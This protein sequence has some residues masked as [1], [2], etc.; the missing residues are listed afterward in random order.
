MKCVSHRFF[1]LLLCSSISAWL[2]IPIPTLRADSFDWRNVNGANWNT[3]VQNQNGGT[4]WVFSGV[5]SFEARYKLTRNDPT[6]DFECSEQQVEW[7]C[8]PTQWGGWGDGS[9]F[10]SVT[11]GLV[12]A[13]ECPIDPNPDY[14]LSPGPTSLW[15]LAAGWQNRMLIG[16]N[17]TV[18]TTTTPNTIQGASQIVCTTQNIKNMLKMYG[19]MMTAVLSTNDLYNSPA[20]I[21][22]NYRPPLAGVDHAV[23]VEG[24]QDDASLPSGGYWIIKNSWGATAG[25]G[26]GYYDVPYGDLEIHGDIVAINTAV[27]YTGAMATVTWGGGTGT[28]SLGGGNWS[29]S[30]QYGNALPTYAWE[31]KETAATF[32]T[33]GGSMTINGTVIAH[34][35]TIASGATGYVF[36]GVN[37]GALTVTAGGITAHESVAFNVPVWIGAPQTWT[38]DSGKS[39]TIGDLHTIVSNLTINAAGNFYTSGAIDGGGVLNANGAAPGSVTFAGTGNFYAT[40]SSTVPVNLVCNS[41]GGVYLDTP[42]GQT[43]TWSGNISGTGSGTIHKTDQGMLIVSGSASYSGPTS[44]DGG[45]LQVSLPSGFLTLN[46]GVYQSNSSSAGTFTRGLATSGS[47]KFEWTAAGG[48]FAAGAG[49]LTVNVG[50]SSTAGT[51]TWG[52]TPGTNIIGTLMFGSST[53]LNATIFRNPVNLNGADRTI[54]VDDNPASAAD[55][56]AMQGAVFNNTGTAGL[57]KTGNGVLCLTSSG[58]NYNGNTTIS[59]GVLEENLPANSFLSLQ[60]G[61]YETVSGGTF[62]RSLGSSGGTFC[63]TGNGGGFSTYTSPLT[64]NVGGGSATLAW[65]TN[66]G[67]QIVGTLM[68]GST[69]WTSTVTFLNPIDL[70]GGARTISVADNPN[71]TADYAALPVAI[72]DSVGGGSLLKAGEGTL[73]LQGSASNTYSGSTTIQGTLVAA[74][75]GGA[76]ALPGNVTLL[77][78]GYGY[79]SVLQLNGNGELASSCF[80]TFNAPLGGSRLELNGHSQTLSGIS[81][82]A[83]AVIEGLLNN[84]GLN[85]DSLLTV[86]N[87]SD[88]T[89]LGVIRNSLQGTGTGKVNLLKTGTASLIL[90]GTNTYTGSTTVSGG[91]LQVTGSIL[92]TAA[93]NVSPGATLYFNRSDGY[94]GCTSPISGSGT[95]QIYQGANTCSLGTGGNTSLSGFA[96]TVSIASGAACLSSVNGLGSGAVNVAAGASYDLATS[97]TSTFSTPITLNG[98]GGTADGVV[99]PALYGDG[100]GAVYT[101]SGPITLAATSDVGNSKNN[102]MLTLSGQISGPGGLVVENATPALTNLAGSITIA[103][104]ASNNYGGNTTIDRGVVYLQKS[105]GA[106]A[107]PG[108][109]TIS[110]GGNTNPAWNTF[111]ILNGSNQIASSAVLNFVEVRGCYSYFELL[112][113]NQTLAGLS[114]NL[115]RGIIENTDQE[116]G[117]TNNCTLTINN[118][119]DCT[120]SG[121]IRNGDLAANAAS[122]GLLALVKSGPGTLTLTGWYCGDYTGGLTVNAGTLDYSGATTLPGTP[123]AYPTGPTGPTSPAVISPCPY[124]INGGTLNIGGLSASIGA[125]QISGGTLTG[126]GTLNSNAAYDVRGGRIDANLGGSGIGVT[127]SGPTTAVL[128]GMNSYTGCTTVTGGTLELGPSAQNCVL[129]VGGA[130]IQ[131]GSLVFDYAAGNDPIATIQSLLKASYDGGH[132][133]VGQFRDSTAA[134]TG[135]TLGCVDNTA[136]DQVKVMATYP[137]DFNLDGVVDSRDYAIWAGNVFTGSTWQQGDA[138]YDGVVNGLDRDLWLANVG[139]PQ[140]SGALPTASVTSV[141]E[142]STLALLAAALLGLLAYAWGKRK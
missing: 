125:F 111:L 88:C 67:T 64:V 60:G 53:S 52:S 131:S 37:N 11:N 4:C 123:V 103:G 36:N 65:G 137:G 109:V 63:F 110:S 97:A 5:A 34:G 50:G 68:F 87:S 79:A 112:G 16:A 19:P 33:V 104:S 57:I 13:T 28:W 17:T 49:S 48:G 124:T 94:L 86:N 78:T 134:A 142:P 31:N 116:S 39:L 2:L 133:D 1:F 117:I 41:T 132:W 72:S 120:Y 85:T 40:G 69:R 122:T 106:I 66:T 27:Y 70:N 135:L 26:T 127:K 47:N 10:Y 9:V 74:K 139:L 138:N 76:L 82:D 113:N 140:L 100:S 128:N 71:A 90:G 44:I 98:I 12:S 107:I 42:A 25:D 32:N 24:Y 58:N 92:S 6:F 21:L 20:D 15:P 23:A 121:H 119:T 77:E 80:L 81:G 62:S 105:G 136:T 118:T 141:P 8:G 35:I 55:Y 43:R 14:W 129:N 102:G 45:V 95:V 73:Y 115:G 29:G 101:L 46:G 91:T 89:F 7:G 126:T 75:T 54:N 38:I 99:R 130:D 3:P 96:G 22:A 93:V 59:G 61:V 51:L 84:T 18:I 114:D 83:N 108:N 56:T 30:D